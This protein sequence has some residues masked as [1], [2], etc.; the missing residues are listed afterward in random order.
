MTLTG[1]ET[2]PSVES[3]PT[4]PAPAFAATSACRLLVARLSLGAP[5]RALK[6]SSCDP[7]ASAN[8]RGK[9]VR[10]STDVSPRLQAKSKLQK[11]QDHC[12][13]PEIVTRDFTPADR[14]EFLKDPFSPAMHMVNLGSDL[15]DT[16]EADARGSES[17]NLLGLVALCY[18]F[19][20]Y[21]IFFLV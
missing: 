11:D 10:E 21:L 9:G 6:D 12:D 8:Q 15:Y 1:K 5:S 14:E 3:R 13:D 20:I 7:L 2:S 19:I 17:G 18:V 4:S 16:W